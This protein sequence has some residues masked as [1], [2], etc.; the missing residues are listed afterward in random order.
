MNDGVA[1]GIFHQA[2]RVREGGCVTWDQVVVKCG[3]PVRGRPVAA[4]LV[5]VP[6]KNKNGV[7]AQRKQSPL[8]PGLLRSADPGGVLAR[9]QRQCS[10]AVLGVQA[11]PRR[12][13]AMARRSTD[14]RSMSN[15]RPARPLA[16]NRPESS[17]S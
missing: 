8:Q 3:Q 6:G 5:L 11:R 16:V 9:E 7:G 4:G 10:Q 1:V 14:E 17:R 13:P 2:E 15:M 12:V